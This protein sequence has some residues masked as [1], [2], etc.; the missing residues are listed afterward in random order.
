MT[1]EQR[2]SIIRYAQEIED[3]ARNRDADEIASLLLCI[4]EIITE[5]EEAAG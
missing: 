5:I 2:E 3:A 1:D 4:R